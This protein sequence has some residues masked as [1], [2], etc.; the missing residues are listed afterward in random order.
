MRLKTLGLI[1]VIIGLLGGVVAYASGLIDQAPEY[2]KVGL[3]ANGIQVL[4]LVG[5]FIDKD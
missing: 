4:G 3:A 2:Y 1:L 5:I